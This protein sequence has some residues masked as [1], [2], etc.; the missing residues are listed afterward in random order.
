MAKGSPLFKSPPFPVEDAL[1]RLGGNLRISRLRRNITLQEVAEK[2][3]VS[4]YAV[5]DAER[6]KP[7]AGIAIYVA[8][9]WVYGLLDQM[10]DV[11]DPAKD[12]EGQALAIAHGRAHA[13]PTDGLD[14]DF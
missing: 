14:N 9:L 8:L 6:G 10:N 11:A 1:R 5:A 3:G 12:E 7:S 13:Y 4:R 2:I